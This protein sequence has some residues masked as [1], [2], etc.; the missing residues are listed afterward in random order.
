VQESWEKPSWVFHLSVQNKTIEGY[1]TNLREK[2]PVE[3]YTSAKGDLFFYD[4][5]H[6][7]RTQQGY[8]D[9]RLEDRF[10]KRFK[11]KDFAASR[12]EA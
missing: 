9:R 3:S 2:I 7:T 6:T 1:I 10:R 11:Q 8:Y 12:L 4:K 5:S